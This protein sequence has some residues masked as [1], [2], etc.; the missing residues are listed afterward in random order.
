MT[1]PAEPLALAPNLDLAA[2]RP[3]RDALIARR[4]AAL[5]IDASDVR[6]LGAP[7]LQV[8]VAARQDW[9]DAGVTL[10]FTA[11][12]PEF[13]EALRLMGACDLLPSGS[14]Q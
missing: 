4:G 3:L 13:D 9:D 6:R 10:R 11:R 5:E 1:S 12:S 7:C 14:A 8:L 2:A